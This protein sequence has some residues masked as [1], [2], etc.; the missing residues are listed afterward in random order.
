MKSKILCFLLIWGLM[1]SIL[2]GLTACGNEDEEESSSQE[3]KNSV[4]ETEKGA[5][6]VAKDLYD[7]NKE[8]NI[9]SNKQ[10][11]DLEKMTFNSNFESYDGVQDYVSIKTLLGCVV[12]NNT[13]NDKIVIVNY[14]GEKYSDTEDILEIRTKLSNNKKYTVSFEYESGVIS[15]IIIK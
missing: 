5:L 12:A 15:E 1:I 13:S 2:V 10:L 7:Y 8:T 4:E 11:D 3:Y 9:V 6:E 14:D